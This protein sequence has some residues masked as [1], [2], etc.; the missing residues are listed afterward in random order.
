MN[1][2]IFLIISCISISTI[3]FGQDKGYIAISA[4]PS[5]PMGDFASTDSDNEGAGLAKTGSFFD[6]SFV[7][8]FGTNL[9][10]TLLLRGQYNAIDHEP[11]M[12]GLIQEE[13]LVSWEVESEGWSLGT[14]MGGVYGSFP[15]SPDKVSFETRVMAGIVS[16]NSPEILITGTDAFSS[17]WVKQEHGSGTAFGYLVG[18]GFK[19][20]L[21]QR[22]ALLINFDY[23]ATEPEFEDVTTTTSIGI[24]S[25]NTFSQSITTINTGVGLAYRW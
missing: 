16:A 5:F 9:G 20:N 15:L 24:F 12:D 8:K 21:G 14:L 22:L 18:V 17:A 4:G 6:L 7:Q 2:L 19:F 10:M 3:T 13:P 23:L 11:I 1:R 25:E